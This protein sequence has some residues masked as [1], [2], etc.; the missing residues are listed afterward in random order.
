MTVLISAQDRNTLLYESFEGDE[1][2]PP[3]WTLIDADGDGHNWI[4]YDM[5]EAV[6]GYLYAASS[7]YVWEDLY[8]DNYLISPAISLLGESFF[9]KY[10]IYANTAMITYS[11]LVSTTT[12]T[13]EAFSAINTEI[14]V[15]TELQWQPR[16]FDLSEYAGETIY[17]AF[18][19]HDRTDG[20]WMGIDDI[21]V[22]EQHQ[23]N[24]LVALSIK[25]FSY[26]SIQV[27]TTYTI[28]VQNY[29]NIPA[30][31]YTVRL[32][33]GNTV[34][35]STVA[36]FPLSSAGIIEFPLT[37]IPTEEG[38]MQIYGEIVWD[39]DENTENN[40]TVPLNIFVYP[41]GTHVVYVGDTIYNSYLAFSLAPVP[42][43][44][45]YHFPSA[46]TQTI[47]KA[48]EFIHEGDLVLSQ[49][50]YQYSSRG[51]VPDNLPIEVYIAHTELESYEYS[52]VNSEVLI[53]TSQFTKVFDG[54]ISLSSAGE[55]EVPIVFDTPFKYN[56]GNLAVM[57]HTPWYSG[58]ERD[59]GFFLCTSTN[60]VPYVNI[61]S[62][63]GEIIDINDWDRWAL[64]TAGIEGYANVKF[65]FTVDE[66]LADSDRPIKPSITSL[67]GNYPNPFNPT[68]TISFDKE[69]V[70]NV[71]IEIF[72]IRGQ[73]VRVLVDEE[74][75]AGSHKVEWNGTDT[76]GR[77][78]ASGIY[79]YRMT[80]DEVIETKRMVLLK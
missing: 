60:N 29:G 12:P 42:I 66:E 58:G 22:F 67:H 5:I 46:A 33:E 16:F 70:G 40:K 63:I 62:D 1:F 10:Y 56:G 21:S 64:L 41:K 52:S 75:F 15:C 47:Y 78:V 71:L 11:V 4:V 73:R 26:P 19:H 27:P 31:G 28:K 80:T 59:F 6:T 77:S 39:L 17:I 25:G 79:F 50:V 30:L 13:I 48:N 20:G 69:S 55:Y 61:A 38:E 2:P 45:D 49:I 74:F 53:P 24:D 3:D 36:P 37:W 14:Q 54:T 68:T 32:M 44:L 57:V 9:L 43:L 76:S 18:R 34:L 65:I 23:N 8:P 51:G 72:N 7:A 35:T